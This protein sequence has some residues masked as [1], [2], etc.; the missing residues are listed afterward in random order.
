MNR[1][2]GYTERFGFLQHLVVPGR[3]VVGM[4]Q[5]VAVPFNEAGEQRHAGQFDAPGVGW[6]GERL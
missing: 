6:D 3:L 1:R 4:Q 5:E 2:P